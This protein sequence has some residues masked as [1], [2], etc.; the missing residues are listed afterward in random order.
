MK[1]DRCLTYNLS[2]GLFDRKRK[3]RLH[4]YYIEYEDKYL[5][6]GVFTRINKADMLDIKFNM[7]WIIW[8]RF[9]VGCDFRIDIK[10]RENGIFK[11]KFVSYFRKN[12][13]YIEAFN[14]IVDW[15]WEHY[16]QDI[17]D[18]H[19]QKLS[20]TRDLKIGGVRLTDEGVHFPE[21]GQYIAWAE[22]AVKEYESYFAVYD[23]KNPEL[24]KRIM[25]D[26][27]ESEILLGMIE[28]LKEKH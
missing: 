13:A 6:T 16:L 15:M 3:L 14:Q 9:F 23:Q 17:I 20:G 25:F 4:P 10:T 2:A 12:T 26:E 8:Y 21:K 11:I 1:A 19:L 5:E 28:A 27:W 24:N 22:V 7:N 18:W